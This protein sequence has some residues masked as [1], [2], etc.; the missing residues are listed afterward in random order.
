MGQNLTEK[1]I[2][3]HLLQGS[4]EPGHEAV[5]YV[6]LELTHDVCGPP[7]IGIH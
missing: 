3:S 4:A 6:D 5:V 1:I 2:A 7:T